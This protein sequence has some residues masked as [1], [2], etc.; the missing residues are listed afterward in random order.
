MTRTNLNIFDKY[1]NFDLELNKLLSIN[2]DI[3]I[4]GHIKNGQTDYIKH[5]LQKNKKKYIIVSVKYIKNMHILYHKI[6]KE[7]IKKEINQSNIEFLKIKYGALKISIF[8]NFFEGEYDINFPIDFNTDI[9][10]YIKIL[11]DYIYKD[12]TRKNFFLVL[13][14]VE[15]LNPDI[16]KTFKKNNKYRVIL[17]KHIHIDQLASQHAPNE[18]FFPNISETGLYKYS[19]ELFQQKN[20][21]LSYDSFKKII[22]SS[23]IFLDYNLELIHLLYDHSLQKSQ[24]DEYF[25]ESGV[26]NITNKYDTQ[27]SN[28]FYNLDELEQSLLKII[29]ENSNSKL[30][31]KELISK[32][33]INKPIHSMSISRKLDNLI[34]KKFI[35]KDNRLMK[36]YDPYFQKWINNHFNY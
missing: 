27:F 29:A 9:N 36:F 13:D 3:S 15:E 4:I 23:G 11:N 2:D 22:N 1:Q 5:F 25:I 6:I 21:F 24:V 10:F 28:I 12:I 31:G 7:M 26:N 18:L 33:K 30:Y 14:H 20:V 16:I 17:S 32:L 8:F 34:E 35:F 19:L